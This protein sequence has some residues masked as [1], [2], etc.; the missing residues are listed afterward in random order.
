MSS[1]QYPSIALFFNKSKN[2]SLN[3]KN[4]FVTTKSNEAINRTLNEDNREKNNTQKE[5]TQNEDVRTLHKKVQL[6]E[7][8]LKQAKT[9][10]RKANDINMQKDLQIQVLKQ[11]LN[12]NKKQSKESVLLFEKHAHRFDSNDIMKIRSIKSGQRHDSAFILGVLRSLYKNNETKIKERRV[13][14]RKYNNITKLEISADKKV[15]MREMLEERVIGESESVDESDEIE[16][17][18][19]KF[20]EHMRHAL[21]NSIAAIE[22]TKTKNQTINAVNIESTQIVPVFPQ[23]NGFSSTS[24]VHPMTP[25]LQNAAHFHS[26]NPTLYPYSSSHSQLPF[27]NA[28]QPPLQPPQHYPYYQQYQPFSM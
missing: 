16:K 26:Y 24:I 28:S 23:T 2:D 20:N 15:I 17:R 27:Q 14:S 1:K 3:N 12:S 10:L 4:S 9:L 25:A 18:L 22:K 5:N 11:Q 8:E 13:T 6:L 21:R 7:K 19:K